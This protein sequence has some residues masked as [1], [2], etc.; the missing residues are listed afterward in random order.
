MGRNTLRK[1][2]NA[3]A[4]GY[5]SFISYVLVIV[6]LSFITIRGALVAISANRFLML[7]KLY[8]LLKVWYRKSN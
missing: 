8:R 5:S 6:A 4:S 1:Y 2:V 7:R 3:N